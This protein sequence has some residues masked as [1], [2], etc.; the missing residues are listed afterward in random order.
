MCPWCFQPAEAHS[1]LQRRLCTRALLEPPRPGSWESIRRIVDRSC[2]PYRERSME[3]GKPGEVL[4]S[5]RLRWWSWFLLGLYHWFIRRRVRAALE[6]VR[7]VGA[8]YIVRV[9]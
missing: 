6:E 7:P 8:T 5:I 3:S 4:I 2:G 9:K 1:D